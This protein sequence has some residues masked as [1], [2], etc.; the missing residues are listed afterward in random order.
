[1][2][3]KEQY[4]DVFAYTR[5]LIG[6]DIEKDVEFIIKGKELGRQF[7]IDYLALLADHLTAYNEMFPYPEF[8]PVIFFR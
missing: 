7:S 3:Y 1:M 8:I 2:D 6:A 5:L 4:M